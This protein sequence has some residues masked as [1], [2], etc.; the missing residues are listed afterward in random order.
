ML[1]ETLIVNA[2]RSS[3]PEIRQRLLKSSWLLFTQTMQDWFAASRATVDDRLM[4]EAVNACMEALLPTDA[5]PIARQ[6][7]TNA[8]FAARQDSPIDVTI[9]GL[10]NNE[11]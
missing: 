11:H 3:L 9:Y 8:R 10:D 5:G 2:L 6:I 7:L 4:R 1:E